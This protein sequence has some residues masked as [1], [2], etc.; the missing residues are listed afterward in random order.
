[1]LLFDEKRLARFVTQ[2]DQDL[3]FGVQYS[4]ANNEITLE[5]HEHNG[6]VHVKINQAPGS[7]HHFVNGGSSPAMRS[8]AT[9]DSGEV[10]ELTPMPYKNSK[11]HSLR[12]RLHNVR[13]GMTKIREIERVT[14]SALASPESSASS[15][16]E[17]EAKSSASSASCLPE[18]AFEEG[19]A[20]GSMSAPPPPPPPPPPPLS[21]SFATPKKPQKRMTKLHWRPALNRG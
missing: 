10:D 12:N 6:R 15:A 2:L 5:R 11:P 3:H 13:G 18:N 4:S 17:P 20:V 19:M 8:P 21:T 1:M 16:A 9:T 14:M 7:L